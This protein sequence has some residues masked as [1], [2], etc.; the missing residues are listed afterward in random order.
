MDTL[1]LS[2]YD[3]TLPKDRI[4]S[5]PVSPKESAKL[6]VFDRA[7]DTITHATFKDFPA[8][9]PKNTLLVFNNTK[10]LSARIYGFKEIPQSK[11]RVEALFHKH[12]HDNI[13]LLQFK[14]R[15]KSGH[16][17]AFPCNVYARILNDQNHLGAGFKEAEFFT[18][19]SATHEEKPMEKEAF[20][21]F[22]EKCGHIPLPPYLKRT[23]TQEDKDSY[24][25]VFAK[26]LGA[27]AAPTAS[28]HFSHESYKL[29]QENFQTTE[30]TLHVGAGTF[31]GV[32]EENILNHKMHKESFYLSKDSADQI[33]SA[34]HITAIG[35]T[36]AR[37]IEEFA[38]NHSLSG[39]CDLFLHP[40]NPPMR[41]NALLTNF[42]LP[43]TTLLMLVASF[44]GLEKTRALY[45]E[46]ITKKYRFYS[47]GDGM[48]IL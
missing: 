32:Q 14:G 38:R 11:A 29:L 31:V 30:I 28:L 35:T 44:I 15:I 21:L 26:H 1:A 10:V 41:V 23:D 16:L 5:F 27:I 33:E 18:R 2:S 12:L 36:S 45:E 9:L 13:Y 46:A 39:E 7:K 48:L 19:D 6:L 43:K 40:A 37:V 17:I 8:F 42:H 22:L 34:P 25:T 47:Y 24:Q 3:Y 20:V 4:A